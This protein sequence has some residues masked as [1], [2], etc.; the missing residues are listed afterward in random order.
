MQD[1]LGSTVALTDA[2][3]SITASTTYDSYGNQTGSLGTRFAYT[4]RE[5]NAFTGLYYYRARFYDANLGRFLSE[6][7]I[8]LNGGINQFGYVGGNPINRIDPSGLSGWDYLERINESKW[9]A[10]QTVLEGLETPIQFGIG[11]G[12]N[13]LLGLSKYLRPST[14]VDECSVAYQAGEWTGFAVQMIE[15]GLGLYEAGGKIALKSL[16][17]NRTW[18]KFGE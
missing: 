8:G 7:P 2:T 9:R 14:G 10:E 1:H 5:L 15:G 4:G 16:L 11:L 13:V 18:I 6:D 17:K 3:G 12:D